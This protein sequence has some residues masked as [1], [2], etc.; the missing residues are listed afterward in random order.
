MVTLF[1]WAH[2]ATEMDYDCR[3]RDGKSCALVVAAA[4]EAT[5]LPLCFLASIQSS[6][7]TATDLPRPGTKVDRRRLHSVADDAEELRRV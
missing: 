3:D 7:P 1:V 5:L 6:H 2:F 4:A